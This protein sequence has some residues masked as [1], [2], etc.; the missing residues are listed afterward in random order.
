MSVWLTWG[1]FFSDYVFDFKVSCGLLYPSQELNSQ[2]IGPSKKFV[3]VF[4]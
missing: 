4:Q 1:G 2:N 3:W